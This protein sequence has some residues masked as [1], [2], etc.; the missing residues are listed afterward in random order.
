MTGIFNQKG[1]QHQSSYIYTVLGQYNIGTLKNSS[2]FNA[3][4][5]R[6]NEIFPI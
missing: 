1:D 2:I 3:E 4:K 6:Q 5:G